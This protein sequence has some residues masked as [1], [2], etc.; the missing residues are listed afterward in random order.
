[1]TEVALREFQVISGRNDAR[2]SHNDS[3]ITSGASMEEFEGLLPT[4]PSID[5]R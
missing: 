4:G 5:V 3:S 2:Q 1:M